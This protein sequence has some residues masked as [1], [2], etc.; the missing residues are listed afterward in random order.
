MDTYRTY[1][2]LRLETSKRGWPNAPRHPIAAESSQKYMDAPIPKEL[3]FLSLEGGML[4]IWNRKKKSTLVVAKRE[5]R[6]K[7]AKIE[8]RK[9][10]GLE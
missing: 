7:P 8:Q 5:G 9:V 3:G 10:Q 1:W 2:T 4:S 6:E